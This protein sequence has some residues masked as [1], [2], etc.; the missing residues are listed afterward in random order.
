MAVC[1][2]NWL[3][4]MHMRMH[5]KTCAC[6]KRYANYNSPVKLT[7]RWLITD[8]NTT[9]KGNIILHVVFAGFDSHMERHGEQ[10]SQLPA[11]LPAV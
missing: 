8:V 3:C 6:A 4:S 2:F 1:S 10:V 9:A 7:H 5:R 11:A